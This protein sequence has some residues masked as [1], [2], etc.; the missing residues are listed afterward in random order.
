MNLYQNILAI[1][2]AFF[3]ALTI[4]LLKK[5]FNDKNFTLINSAVTRVGLLI[6]TAIVWCGYSYFLYNN[7]SIAQFYAVIKIIEI[8][9][10]IVAG[11]LYFNTKLNYVNYVGLLLICI[12]VFCLE[13]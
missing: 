2:T 8:C 9:V 1:I 10:P 3:A 7:V 5:Y 6:L 13:Y 4:I 11:V 12:A